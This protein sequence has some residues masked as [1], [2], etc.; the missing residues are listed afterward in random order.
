MSWQKKALKYSRIHFN[1][2]LGKAE[3][4]GLVKK[5]KNRWQELWT[6][7]RK[8]RHLLELYK[9]VGNVRDVCAK[10]GITQ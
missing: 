2:P 5:I 10:E 4:K 9:E 3:I 8:G 7:E 1:V 6:Q